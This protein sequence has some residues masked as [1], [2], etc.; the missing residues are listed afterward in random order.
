MSILHRLS[1]FHKFLILGIVALLM[2]A[3]PTGLYLKQSQADI[4]T[5][6]L[7]AQGTAPAIALQTVVRLTQ[8]HRGIAAGMLGGNDVLAAKR[9]E[10]RDALGKAMGSVDSSLKTSGA[11]P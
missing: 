11:S 3:L 10:T 6:E 8:Q 5:A 9:P 2:T 1:L 4:D 7:E